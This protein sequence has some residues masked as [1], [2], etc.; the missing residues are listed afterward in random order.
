MK[1]SIKAE[2]PQATKQTTPVTS[3]VLEQI[4][5]ISEELKARQ[6]AAQQVSL[7]LE[8]V[9]STILAQAGLDLQKVKNLSVN[10]ELSVLEFELK[11][12]DKS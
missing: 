7:N 3:T 9:V 12:D 11:E 2:L 5:K 6:E 4:I 10:R 1:K 8:L